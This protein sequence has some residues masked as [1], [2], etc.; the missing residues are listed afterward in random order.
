MEAWR[1]VNQ[2]PFGSSFPMPDGVFFPND[3]SRLPALGAFQSIRKAVACARRF[4]I[5][6]VRYGASFFAL[7]ISEVAHGIS[8]MIQIKFLTEIDSK[9]RDVFQYETSR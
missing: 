8:P 7:R 2:P 1:Y 6:A 9:R 3:L 5:A 4:R